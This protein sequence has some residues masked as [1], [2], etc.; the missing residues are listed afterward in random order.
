MKVKNI[1]LAAVVA[2]SAFVGQ[3]YAA[4]DSYVGLGFGSAK[5]DTAVSN[6]GGTATLDEKDSAIKLFY[7]F[8]VAPRVAVELHYADFGETSLKGNNG[9][10]FDI[11][12]SSF[13]FTANNASIVSETTSFGV[14]G[15]FKLFEG[16]TFNPYLKAGVH[17]WSF[18]ATV[19]SA[20][21][22]TASVSDDGFDVFFGLGAEVKLSDN[23][24]VTA[25]FESYNVGDDDA[26]VA[27]IA[28]K[29]V[30]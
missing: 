19:S 18:D 24:F 30:F 7:G 29:F 3:A 12:S 23:F 25:G 15:V 4:N 16:A 27:T 6:V 8:N 22:A 26:A 1:V 13:S 28:A 5:Y 17:R 9:D 2:T 11:G 10:T 14:A 20:S 21:S